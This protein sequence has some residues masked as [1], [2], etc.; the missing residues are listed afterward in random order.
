VV[1]QH[2]GTDNA[3]EECLHVVHGR[4]VCALAVGARAVLDQSPFALIFQ[5]KNNWNSYA[6]L[7]KGNPRIGMSPGSGAAVLLPA[8]LKA[9]GLEGKVRRTACPP[10]RCRSRRRASACRAFRSSRV[11]T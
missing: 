10:R 6:D 11:T 7:A 2:L 4:L 3:A 5:K 9:A 8:V 1:S